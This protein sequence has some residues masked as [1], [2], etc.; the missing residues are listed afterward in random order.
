MVAVIVMHILSF[1]LL[2]QVE[3]KT[4]ENET[5]KRRRKG[6]FGAFE[7]VSAEPEQCQN[8]PSSLIST[9]AEE[10]A[11]VGGLGL[12]LLCLVGTKSL[13]PSNFECTV[14]CVENK[15]NL[16]KSFR[17]DK[18]IMSVT[19]VFFLTQECLR[20]RCVCLFYSSQ[21]NYLNNFWLKSLYFL[22]TLSDLV[23]FLTLCFVIPSTD[24]C[25]LFT[26]LWG[27]R[28][29]FFSEFCMLSSVIFNML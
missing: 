7:E 17:R 26:V 29:Y 22:S 20:Y 11:E 12:G 25:S 15:L 1:A 6:L 24:A 9:S 10:A 13:S 23:T 8:I 21:L 18:S 5:N 16:L 14:L 2:F 19:P 4:E 28:K 27:Q 3:G